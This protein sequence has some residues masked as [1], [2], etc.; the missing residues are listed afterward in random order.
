MTLTL[1]TCIVLSVSITLRPLLQPSAGRVVG[2][3][4]GV[5]V[6]AVAALLLAGWNDGQA[7]L[8]VVAIPISAGVGWLLGPKA[9]AGDRWTAAGSA[10]L[11]AVAGIVVGSFVV[12]G[13]ASPIWTSSVGEALGW[14]AIVGL[15]G[16][17]AGGGLALLIA[18]PAAIAWAFLVR[19]TMALWRGSPIPNTVPMPSGPRRRLPS[20][21]GRRPRRD[22][23]PG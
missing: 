6:A 16:L 15:V 14:T 9:A 1:A 10:V 11:A 8:G 5:A 13:V 17:I 19:S 21:V 7:G 22:T 3:L 12:A 20:K 23:T 4:Y 18:L 2:A